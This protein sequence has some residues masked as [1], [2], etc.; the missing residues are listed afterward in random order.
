MSSSSSRNGKTAR[1]AHSACIDKSFQGRR[2]ALTLVLDARIP[3]AVGHGLLKRGQRV[4]ILLST[5]LQ[6]LHHLSWRI[7]YI[8]IREADPPRVLHIQKD[9][10]MELLLKLGEY[11]RPGPRHRGPAVETGDILRLGHMSTVAVHPGR[12]GTVCLLMLLP[13]VVG[14]LRRDGDLQVK[15][16]Q[17]KERLSMLRDE[18][19]RVA[20]HRELHVLHAQ[21]A[22]T[23]KVQLGERIGDIKY[24]DGVRKAEGERLEVREARRG[25]RRGQDA[26][27]H[28]VV[29]ERLAGRDEALREWPTSSEDHASEPAQ[30][31]SKIDSCARRW[32][33]AGWSYCARWMGGQQVRYRDSSGRRLER[34]R[35]APSESKPS[36]TEDRSSRMR[37]SSSAG[38]AISPKRMERDRSDGNSCKRDRVWHSIWRVS[39]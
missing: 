20:R 34:E 22:E 35:L 2:K 14:V 27:R 23:R 8:F 1:S 7:R 36:R 38:G 19:L 4:F 29:E 37:S 15:Q 5:L 17:L 11:V 25:A 18:S 12:R 26:V 24:A 39:A 30:W 21:R 6:K 16:V 31:I 32:Q 13:I 33:K 9:E 3:R 10:P 28:R